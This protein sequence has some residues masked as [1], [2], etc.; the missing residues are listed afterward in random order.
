ME[1]VDFSVSPSYAYNQKETLKKTVL[2][3]VGKHSLRSM[4]DIGAGFVETAVPYAQ[5]VSRYLAVEQDAEKVEKLR[6]AGLEVV[7]GKFPVEISERF[8]LVLSSHSIPE[9]GVGGYRPY[10]AA[11]WEL[12]E[13]NGWLFI[14]TFKGTYDA[15]R[16]I[17]CR[18]TGDCS[19]HDE[20]KYKEMMRVLED[21]GRPTNSKVTSRIT[22]DV[23]EDIVGVLCRSLGLKTDPERQAVRGIVEGEL[24]TETGYS[25]PTE[26][27]VISVQKG[28]R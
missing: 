28:G 18:L 22:S 8:D 15:R 4:L 26:H 27:L 12:V 5:A 3:F 21:F 9:D 24:K 25:L 1:K 16:Q 20:E 11:A 17:D 7:A 10:L 2:D 14:I 23:A 6:A 13:P 19:P